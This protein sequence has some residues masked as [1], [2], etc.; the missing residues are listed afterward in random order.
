MESQGGHT[1][2]HHVKGVKEGINEY[3]KG[4]YL[5][6]ENMLIRKEPVRFNMNPPLPQ[7]PGGQAFA[8]VD[9]VEEE[10][11]IVRVDD[12]AGQGI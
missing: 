1:A 8:G 3:L 5:V 2:Y 11:G 9:S 10:G 7:C 6:D 12:H 4:G